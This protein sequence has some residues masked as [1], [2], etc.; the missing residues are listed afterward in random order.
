MDSRKE[1][2]VLETDR[3]RIVGD[4]TLPRTGYR[5]RM[6]D[7]LNASERD[8]IALTDVVLEPID[9]SESKVRREFMAISRRHIVVVM[10]EEAGAG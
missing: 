9:E 3:Y 7:F 5:S 10:P 4:L 2:V 8:F 1:R 6:T